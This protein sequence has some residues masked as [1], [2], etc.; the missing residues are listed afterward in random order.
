MAS[1][2]L[3]PVVSSVLKS[4]EVIAINA[5]DRQLHGDM[6]RDICGKRSVIC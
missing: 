6:S 4:S 2:S 3:S 5:E 1:E